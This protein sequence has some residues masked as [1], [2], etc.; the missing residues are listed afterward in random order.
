MTRPEPPDEEPPDEQWGR[1]DDDWDTPSSAQ[2]ALRAAATAVGAFSLGVRRDAALLIT[3]QPG[4]YTAK[5]TGYGGTT[6]V[7]LIEVYELP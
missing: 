6:G 7:A 2:P 1:P 4:A 3:L 5:V